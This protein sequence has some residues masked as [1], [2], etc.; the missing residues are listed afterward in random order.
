MLVIRIVAL[1][2]GVIFILCGGCT[3]LVWGGLGL[4]GGFGVFALLMIGV[5][6]AALEHFPIRL[7]HIRSF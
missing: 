3:V 2:F 7:D 5:G 6:A 1:V 4:S